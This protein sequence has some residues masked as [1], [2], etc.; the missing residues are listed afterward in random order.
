MQALNLIEP[1]STTFFS[2]STWSPLLHHHLQSYSSLSDS[3]YKLYIHYQ[4]VPT[5]CA[6]NIMLAQR[7][8]FI[9]DFFYG[10]TIQ[11]NLC[12]QPD[13]FG[14][15]GNFLWVW[16][17][18]DSRLLVLGVK[19]FRLCHNWSRAGL[20]MS[21]NKNPVRFLVVTPTKCHLTCQTWVSNKS[22]AL[23]SLS[24]SLFLCLCSGGVVDKD[25]R[26]YLNLRFSKG[27][28]DHDHQQI[29][30]DNLYLRTVPCESTPLSVLASITPSIF[31]SLLLDLLIS[32]V[33]LCL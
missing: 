11:T 15:F 14:I 24:F 29:I 2:P 32:P 4:L 27:S 16:A 3:F 28:V 26:H 30:R 18:F 12:I 5:R 25:L 17:I 1:Y 10:C 8:I 9:K 6:G 23:M 7:K 19:W 31:L 21:W 22:K 33:S 13:M 20:L